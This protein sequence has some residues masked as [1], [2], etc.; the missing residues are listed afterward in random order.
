MSNAPAIPRLSAPPAPAP[1]R[2]DNDDNAMARGLV[3]GLLLSVPLWALIG[4]A[5]AAVF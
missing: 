3:N 1:I 2:H 5:V 4:L